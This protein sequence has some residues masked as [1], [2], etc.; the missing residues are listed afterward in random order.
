MGRAALCRQQAMQSI[1][2][3]QKEKGNTLD[4]NVWSR[5]SMDRVKRKLSTQ[6]S[7]LAQD[8]KA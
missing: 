1:T 8:F 5:E 4:K 7:D 2:E 3:K 6:K